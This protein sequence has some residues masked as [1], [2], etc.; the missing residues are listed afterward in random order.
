MFLRAYRR[1]KDGKS[2]TYFAL[3]ESHRTERGPRQRIVAQL[4]ELSVG[5]QRRWQRTAIFHTR[6]GDGKQLPLFLADEDTP[7]PDDPDVV[8]IR[9]GKVGWTNARAFGDVWLGLQLCQPQKRWMKIVPLA[10]FS[11]TFNA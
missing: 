10:F 5:D 9:L 8:R 7:L 6:H 3:V 2:H 11:A 1:A 4:G